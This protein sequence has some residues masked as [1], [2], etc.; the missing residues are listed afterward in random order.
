MRQGLQQKLQQKIAPQQI[1]FIKMLEVNTLEMEERIKQELEENPALEDSGESNPEESFDDILYNNEQNEDLSL[2]DYRSEDDIPD[3]KLRSGNYSEDNT[4]GMSVSADSSFRD[5]LLDQLNLKLL[6]ERESALT[7][8]V[9]GNIDHDGYLRRD[10]ESMVDDYS[11]HVGI[12]VSDD[13]MREAVKVVQSFEPAGVAAMTLRE[14]LML[15]LERKEQTDAVKLAYKILD[16]RFEEFSKKHFD[17]ILKYTNA[18]EDEFKSAVTEITRLNPKP[19]GAWES[20]Y[21][22]GSSTIIPDYVVENDNG[23]LNILLNS[24]NIPDLQINR[25]YSEMFEEYSNNKSN[26]SKD[27]KDAVLFVKQ[28]LDSA[29]WFINAVKQRQ[30]TLMATMQ[31]IVNKQSEFFISGDETKL[32]PMI[33]KDISDI[34]GFDVSTISRVSNNK[35]VQTDFGIYSLKFFFSESMQNEQG[36]EVSAIEIK[37]IL[38]ECIAGENKRSP[39]TDDK[40]AEILKDKGYVI[41]RRTV[42][43]YREQMNIPVA[44]MRKEI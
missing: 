12:T 30:D 25:N 28:K 2:G 38:E 11:F 8:Y 23:V 1:Q 40:L 21:E 44:R 33:L 17:K 5:F 43:K 35:Y 22:L 13:E 3:Y 34:T 32:K 39:L 10:V 7:E 6:S 9:I 18:S 4:P 31:A 36:E 20:E 14:C 15:Q 16:S 26:Q 41:A 29:K 24:K 42:A 27:M 19:G 37:K